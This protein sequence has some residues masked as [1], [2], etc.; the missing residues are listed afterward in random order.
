MRILTGTALALLALAAVPSAAGAAHECDVRRAH[1]WEQNGVARLFVREWPLRQLYGCL[2][3]RRPRRL[4]R[5]VPGVSLPRFRQGPELG[6]RW[7]LFEAPYRD[8]GS[9][10]LT[11]VNL[12][13][14]RRRVIDYFGAKVTIHTTGAYVINRHGSLAWI[15]C[16]DETGNQT[17]Y[18]DDRLVCT[19]LV[20]LRGRRRAVDTASYLAY[21]ETPPIPDDSLR[22]SD[23]GRV[24]HWIH[25]GQPRSAPL[26]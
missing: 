13:T 26:A 1:V 4:A 12:A 2:R 8:T 14:G 17:D 22:L 19:V 23:R 20:E 5:N 10:A 24:L 25:D 7:A 21:S 6:G 18:R 15:V 3:G 16:V 11:R 9:Y